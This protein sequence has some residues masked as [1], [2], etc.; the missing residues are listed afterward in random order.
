MKACILISPKHI[1]IQEIPKPILKDNEVLLKVVSSGICVNDIR[2]YKGSNWSYPRVG[3]HEYSAIIE[4]TG[5]SV[6]EFSPGDKVVAFITENC[7]FCKSCQEGHE[8]I[9]ENVLKSKK[10]YN[11]N[12]LSGFF[13]F[14]EYIAMPKRFLYKIPNGVTSTEAAFTEPLA[15]VL[16]SIHRCNIQ[17]GQDVVVIGAGVMGLLHVLCL[18]KKGVRVII[19]EPDEKRRHYAVQLGADISIDPTTNDPVSTVKEITN[20]YGADVVINTTA[21]PNVAEQAIQMTAKSGICNMFSSIHPNTPILVDAG[22][23]HSQEI[24][25]TGTQN[26]TKYTFKQALDCIAKKIIDVNPLIDDVFDLYHIKDALE[27]A[28]RPDTYKVIVQ[29]SKEKF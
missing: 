24:F 28:S 25:V 17:M 6:S 7:G 16:N 26:G 14:S 19:S 2:D 18:K 4:E 20:G 13:G 3:G 23:L 15:C 29:I 5:D 27:C 8:N 22:R 11:E 21:I 10:Y 12:G 9:C 1:E